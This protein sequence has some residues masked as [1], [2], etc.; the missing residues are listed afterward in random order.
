V[1]AA[2]NLHFNHESVSVI[3]AYLK[4]STTDN[5]NSGL[6]HILDHHGTERKEVYRRMW[7]V[8]WFSGRIGQKSGSDISPTYVFPD[9]IRDA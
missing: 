5:N 2:Q 6:V 9:E 4:N 3:K 7:Q 8:M 1:F